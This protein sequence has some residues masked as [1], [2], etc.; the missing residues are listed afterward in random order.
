M[1]NEMQ[2]TLLD[3]I[4]VFE[5]VGEFVTCLVK[6]YAS[7]NPT[8]ISNLIKL[9]NDLMIEHTKHLERL[10]SEA[11]HALRWQVC[12]TYFLKKNFEVASNEDFI[13]ALTAC[14]VLFPDGDIFYGSQLEKKYFQSMLAYLKTNLTE[15]LDSDWATMYNHNKYIKLIT[16]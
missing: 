4:L 13:I 9:N 3:T 10:N 2:S 8:E 1:I 16:A 5:N 6:D 14:E 7:Q 15:Y 11:E 12:N